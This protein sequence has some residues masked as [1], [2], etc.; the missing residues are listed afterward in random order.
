[1]PA[2]GERLRQWLMAWVAAI[3][4]CG[5]LEYPQYH[6]IRFVGALDIYPWGDYDF[7]DYAE[8]ALERLRSKVGLQVL[9]STLSGSPL[10]AKLIL[11]HHKYTGSVSTNTRSSNAEVSEVEESKE[12]SETADKSIN[13]Q[14]VKN[15]AHNIVLEVGDVGPGITEQS[16]ELNTMYITNS[17]GSTYLIKVKESSREFSDD[18]S[19]RGVNAAREGS[20]NLKKFNSI[21]GDKC[22]ILTNG[23]WN[24]EWCHR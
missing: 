5:S 19:I 8:D 22:A 20:H 11:P 24:Y 14:Q 21:L 17:R 4:F 12:N 18:K 7:E 6:A 9:E 1:M 15:G 16:S 13:S 10:S 2:V 3:L 23:Y